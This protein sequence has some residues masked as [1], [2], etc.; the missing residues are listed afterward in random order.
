M[1]RSIAALLVTLT[2]L[3]A[4]LTLTAAVLSRTLGDPARPGRILA[5]LLESP[6]GRDVVAD[7]AARASGRDGAEREQVRAAARRA[8][9]SERVREQTA[10][11]TTPRARASNPPATSTPR[12]PALE[13]AIRAELAKQNPELAAQLAKMPLPLALPRTSAG[14]LASIRSLFDQI[15][16]YT[17]LTSVLGALM[18]LLISPRRSEVL[19]RLARWAFGA[20]LVQVLVCYALPRFVLAELSSSYLRA[21]GVVIEAATADLV[22]LFL[23]TLAI[24]GGCWLAARALEATRRLTS[25]PPRNPALPEITQPPR[26]RRRSRAADTE[27]SEP[28]ALS[29][30]SLP[31]LPPHPEAPT[32]IL[33]RPSGEDHQF[34][35]RRLERW[36]RLAGLVAVPDPAP[37]SLAGE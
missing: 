2:T 31:S 34:T 6:D 15:L 7:L 32:R 36:H 21:L 26:P 33:P 22:P 37:R 11:L 28:E 30:D 12:S 29:A 24:A 16:P 13:A 8:L 23:L 10:A 25:P 35:A 1:R 20:S 17:L 9:E 19:R 18:A 14:P 27:S 3:A 4:T 5:A